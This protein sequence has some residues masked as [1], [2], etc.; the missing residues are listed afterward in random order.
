MQQKKTSY[1]KAQ[2]SVAYKYSIDYTIIPLVI[3][4]RR[5]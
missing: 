1:A 4:V 2:N 3:S 5:Y